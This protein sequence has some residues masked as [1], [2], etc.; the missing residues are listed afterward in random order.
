MFFLYLACLI[1]GGALLLVSLLG[2]G[3]HESHT[4]FHHSLGSGGH[5]DA[6]TAL[7]TDTGDSIELQTGHG[8]TGNITDV[9][10]HS[11]AADA[12]KF[13]SFRNIVYFL[14][15]FGLTGTVMDFFPM[16][17][18]LTF[19]SSIGIGGIA[20]EAGYQF[21][22]YLKQS[23]SGET[24]NISDLKGRKAKVLVGMSKSRKGTIQVELG[25]ST[26]KLIARVSDVSEEDAFKPGDEVL[27]I[28]SSNNLLYVVSNDL[29]NL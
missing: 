2:G 7:D 28:D 9:H 26:L 18:F 6:Y 22:K 21:M 20:S 27:I 24:I 3:D 1:F 25:S 19:L 10:S 16:P 8:S 5:S 12:V 23:E 4:D 13:I 14:A 29:S 11:D 17:G 15:F